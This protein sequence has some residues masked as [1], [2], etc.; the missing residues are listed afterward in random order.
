M[1]IQVKGTNKILVKWPEP[2]FQDNVGVKRIR[3]STHN[4]KLR[5]PTTFNVFYDAYDA[6]GNAASC[7][8]KMHIESEL[9]QWYKEKL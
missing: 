1:F 6:V 5:H 7:I 9:I 8:F 2:I 4:N 3:Q